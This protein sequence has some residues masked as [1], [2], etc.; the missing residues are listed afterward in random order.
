[1]IKQKLLLL[2][3]AI[4]GIGGFLYYKQ[5][6][7]SNNLFTDFIP[8][9]TLVLLETNEISTTKNSVIPRIPL[10][11]KA[12]LQYQI[13]K[14]IG[15]TQSDIEL[16]IFKKTLYFA[17]LPAGKDDFAF[18][19]YLPLTSDHQNFTET[20]SKLSQN[21]K[22]KRLIPHT[23]KGYKVWEVVDENTKTIIS[24][25][26]KDNFLIFS[27]SSLALEESILHS[28]KNWAKSLKLQNTEANSA[29]IFTRT[30]F[31]QEAIHT[32]LK[33]I[34]EKNIANFSSLIPSSLEWLKP[35]ENVVE[36][37]STSNQADIF[38]GQQSVQI[39]SLNM[40]PNSC[41]YA[42]ILSFTNREKFIKNLEQ[43]LEE[44]KKIN[45]LRTKASSKF[46]I[47]FN[48][49][50]QKI[51]QEV[52]LCSFDNSEQ[53]IQNK[54][55]LFKQKGLLNPLKV[56]AENVA[57][58]S[59]N[60]VFR[61]QYGSFLITSLGIREFPTM[62]FG[63]VYAG[64]EECYFTEYKD[65]IILASNLHV[66]Q[67]YLLNLSKGDVFSNSPKGKKITNHCLPANLTL[68]V[69][70]SKA[71]E[72]LQ[73]MLNPKWA[74]QLQLYKP[75]LSDVQAEILQL[76]ASGGR[77]VLLKN[78]ALTKAVKNVNNKWIK[79]ESIPVAAATKPKY[80]INPVNKNAQIL[81]QSTDH[82]LCLFEKGK[83]IWRYPLNGV[84]V[85][86][87]KSVNY[88]KN[89]AQEL[90]IATKT[91]IYILSRNQNGFD[92]TT[93]KPFNP[94]NLGNFSLFK[95]DQIKQKTLI[96]ENGDLFRLDKESLIL[97]PV[98][99]HSKVS[100]SLT[101]LPIILIKGSEY[102]VILDKNG[103]LSLQNAKGQIAEGFPIRL[104]GS[105]NSPPVFA[106][107]NNLLVIRIIS[108]QGDLYKM[109][110]EG[111][112]LEKRQLFRSN[113][114]VKFS[115]AVDDRNTDWAI[116]RTDGKEVVVLNK[117]EQEMFTIKG[118]SYG[119][120]VLNFYNL[121]I[122]GSYFSIHNGYTTYQFF[123]ENGQAIG[124]VPIM[125]KY[126]PNIKYSDSYKKIIMNIT[127]P[128]SLETWSVKLD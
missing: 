78:I 99:K 86:D 120:K 76:N 47:D 8:D 20:L 23:T 110:L 65:Y 37:I 36:A 79:L 107:E 25:I 69:E 81:L 128:S 32:F 63:E 126:K 52:T 38:E 118:L 11:K 77:L 82:L 116:M 121:G 98:V 125:S 101:P 64:F 9:N 87:I 22:G 48:E 44:Q 84:I 4:L 30:H 31:N 56:I 90:L 117:N 24:Y 113:N 7:E 18:I 35:E 91:K 53:A 96:S 17:L 88:S 106:S 33:D 114:E 127:T 55:V 61:L 85:G 100:Q 105:F 14:K 54:V 43:K 15:L 1:M 124:Q 50:Y 89:D 123:N 92:V 111:K 6:S 45:A 28:E 46:E 75:A 19:N 95:N 26:I 119:R 71:L 74:E 27:Q 49:F 93:S 102:A 57:I 122:A 21:N 60:D 41:S 72:G 115:M 40:I 39:Q 112:L 109:S 62:L 94:Y 108:E 67:E 51:N 103:T 10:L 97:S 2:G 70:N 42:L 73:T 83:Q 5:T 29:A 16:L 80:L 59:Q 13:L 3:F 68:I 66:M 104:S 12:S 34:S 58:K